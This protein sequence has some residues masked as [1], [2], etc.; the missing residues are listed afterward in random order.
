MAMALKRKKLTK[1]DK[2]K[3]IQEVEKYPTMSRNEI[4]KH[5]RLPPS[6]LSN[7]ILRKASILEEKSRC[8]ARS[9]KQKTMKT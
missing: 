4:A 1:S 6:S 3:I 8:G 5:F 7:I 9:E 2:V